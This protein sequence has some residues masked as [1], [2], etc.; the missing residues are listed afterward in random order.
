METIL[1]V[2]QM[3]RVEAKEERQRVKEEK[4]NRPH[5]QQEGRGGG[6]RSMRS[7]AQQGSEGL[8]KDTVEGSSTGRK[9]NVGEI[10][11]LLPSDIVDKSSSLRRRPV[12]A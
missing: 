10:E 4:R 8:A 2:I 9:G 12:K 11:E 7:S 1:F 6:V 3:S 5:D